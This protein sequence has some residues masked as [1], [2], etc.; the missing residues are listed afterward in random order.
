MG[1]RVIVG[2]GGFL[3]AKRPGGVYSP[4]RGDLRIATSGALILADKPR[5]DLIA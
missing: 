4:G 2:F 3:I 1:R 5:C